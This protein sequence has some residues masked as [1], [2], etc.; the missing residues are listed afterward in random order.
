MTAVRP[1]KRVAR[2]DLALAALLSEKTIALAAAK[3]GIGETTL[4]RWLAD[5][6]FKARYREARRQVVEQAVAQLQRAASVAVSA[7]SRNLTC[8]NP[9]V[10][11]GAA[12]TILDQAIKGLE[13]V[14]LAERVETLELQFQAGEQERR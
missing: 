10:E 9:S 12:R 4:L 13:L 2:E 6:A 5:P 7:L 1:G 11:V 3:A 14:D 8:G